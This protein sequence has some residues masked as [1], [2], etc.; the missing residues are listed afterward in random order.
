MGGAKSANFVR[1]V[2]SHVPCESFSRNMETEASLVFSDIDSAGPHTNFEHPHLKL[3][4]FK[5]LNLKLV[6]TLLETQ[7]T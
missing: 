2:G 1:G 3:T 6:S 5:N 7:L 4:E